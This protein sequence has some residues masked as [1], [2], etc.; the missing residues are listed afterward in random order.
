MTYTVRR[1][2]H[3]PNHTSLTPLQ[4]FAIDDVLTESIGIGEA[5]PTMRFWI[6]DQTVAIGMQDTRLTSFHEGLHYL[7]AN[8][9]DVI[10][11]PS[12]GLAVVLDTGV[13]NVSLLLRDQGRLS[14]DTGYE[15]MVTMTSNALSRLGATVQVGEVPESYC[16]GRYDLTVN[17]RKIAGISQRRRRGG[18]AVQM[19]LAVDGNQSKRATMIRTFY[20]RAKGPND[21]QRFPDIKPHTMTTLNAELETPV[22]VMDVM[23]A[24]K[25]LWPEAAITPLQASEQKRLEETYQRLLMRHD[26]GL[27]I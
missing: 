15:Q 10:V 19:Y 2:L 9:Y 23:N 11:R 4:S 27:N 25:T 3:H 21:T 20:E 14:I 8:G 12:G 5:E 7:Y 13:L 17:G 26:K 1:I 22:T 16:P 18:I 6:H 24:F